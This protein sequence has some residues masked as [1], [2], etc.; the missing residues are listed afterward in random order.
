MAM[1]VPDGTCEVLIPRDGYDP[2][3]VVE[4]VKGWN[5]EDTDPDPSVGASPSRNS[6][7]RPSR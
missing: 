1:A 6:T 5:R 4:M 3:A 2:F 7:A